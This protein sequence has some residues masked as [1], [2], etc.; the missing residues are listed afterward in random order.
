MLNPVLIIVDNIHFQYNGFMYGIQLLSIYFFIQKQVLLGGILFAILINFKHIYMYQA[1]P[2][3]VYIL[4]V[5]CYEG[6]STK[7]HL[8]LKFE[9]GQIK[10]QNFAK[11]ASCT[12]LV[13]LVSIYPFI[14]DL[15]Q[16]ASR[17][18]PIKRG[19]SHSY[20]AAN[21]WALYAFI[22]R[23]LIQGLSSYADCILILIDKSF[24][25][26]RGWFQVEWF[27]YTRNSWRHSILYSSDTNT[28]GHFCTD[29]FVSGV[30]FDASIE[31]T[32]N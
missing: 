4:G 16:L 8:P 30:S 6:K 26:D 29:A 1:L 19:I 25:L 2:V 21:V 7:S 31:K 5:Y 28:L 20:W 24:P 13:F 17:L 23:L 9:G 27:I 32:H 22:D 18:F 11:I 14:G 15:E 3:F 10:I 12:S